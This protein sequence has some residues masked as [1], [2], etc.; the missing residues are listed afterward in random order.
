MSTK[1]KIYIALSTIVILISIYTIRIYLEYRS[2]A[3]KDIKYE[4]GLSYFRQRIQKSN[5]DL[6]HKK[7]YYFSAWNTRCKPCIQE[8]PL[9][10][11][12]ADSMSKKIG[13][14]YLS[15]DSDKDINSFLKRKGIT[16]RN[17][18]FMNDMNTFIS[19]MYK[20]KNITYKCYPSHIV[21]DS[22]GNILFFKQGS[23]SF[24]ELPQNRKLTKNELSIKNKF[25]DPLVLFLET[26]K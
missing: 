1:N 24:I 20:K 3:I 10:D 2:Y 22:L 18:I 16:S 9:L 17:F 5:P 21:T 14:I 19:A 25:K 23:V 26:L 6:L 4:D 15:D 13:F 11:S 7:Y 12:I 8:M